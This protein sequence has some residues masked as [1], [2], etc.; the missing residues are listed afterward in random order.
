MIERHRCLR[1]LAH[2]AR[3][4]TTITTCSAPT[5]FVSSLRTVAYLMEATW[6]TCD[7]DQRLDQPPP[8]ATPARRLWMATELEGSWIAKRFFFLMTVVEGSL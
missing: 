1:M 5:H 8:T 6:S 2:P 7:G 4:A 3:G